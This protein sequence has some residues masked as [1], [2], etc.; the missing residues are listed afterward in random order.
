VTGGYTNHYTNKDL[1]AHVFPPTN[2]NTT[3]TNTHAQTPHQTKHTH[4]KAKTTHLKQTQNTPKSEEPPITHHTRQ[5]HRQCGLV[6]IHTCT[7]MRHPLEP[8]HQI[9]TKKQHT[10]TDRAT[11]ET[12]KQR[13]KETKNQRTKADPRCSHFDVT[14]DPPTTARSNPWTRELVRMLEQTDMNPW[15]RPEH[16][17]CRRAATFVRGVSPCVLRVASSKRK[18]KAPRPGIEPGSPA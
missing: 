15:D 13:N 3:F 14:S 7:A 8:N 2:K 18:E 9:T 5:C 10:A 1:Q 6:S 17:D 11:K 16:V 4:P 12:K